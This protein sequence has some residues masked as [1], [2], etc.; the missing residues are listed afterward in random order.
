[1]TERAPEWLVEFQALFSRALRRPLSRHTGTLEADTSGYA[2]ALLTSLRSGQSLPVTE[3]MAVYNRQ[4]WF[5][6]FTVLQ[7]AFPLATRIVGHWQLNGIAAEYL[8]QFPPVHVEL[9]RIAD[10]FP[11][12]AAD[13]LSRAELPE[14]RALAFRQALH[15]DAS[16]RAVFGAPES[17]PFRP[18]H[19]DATRLPSCRLVRS[20]TF[21]IVEQSFPLLE[22]RARALRESGERAFELP[23]PSVEP[24]HWALLRR[25]PGVAQLYLEPLEARLHELVT[26]Q[27]LGSALTTLETE[28][29]EAERADLPQKTQEWLAK[30]M[31]VGAF[32]GV[33]P[34]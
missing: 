34:G 6:L 1:M 22:L 21:A 2:P 31:Q 14:A 12:F 20:P 33:E 8:E 7:T 30:A 23:A 27:T 26:T 24:Q 3:Q 17:A 15:V 13:W 28:A 10:G 5:R 11:E 19:A 9:D 29:T 4:Y 16:W 32:S 25:P 18:S